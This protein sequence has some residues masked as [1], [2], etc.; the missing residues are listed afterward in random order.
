MTNREEILA[1]LQSLEQHGRLTAAAVVE[2][3]ADPASPLHGHFEW[4][5]TEA[6]RKHREDQARALIRSYK[7]RVKVH[8]FELLAP[9]FVK[10]PSR[11]VGYT[12]TTRQRVA[13]DRQREILVAE[14]TRASAALKRALAIA[15]VLGLESDVG[16]ILTQMDA[17]LTLVHRNQHPPG[18][19]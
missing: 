14:F 9:R 6:A 15:Q 17:V 3:A 13:D 18:H 10:D 4:N 8:S 7:V 16:S 1:V 11:E 19:A 12:L 5:D 2:E